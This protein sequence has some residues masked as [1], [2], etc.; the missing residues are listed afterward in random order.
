MG[1]ELICVPPC[2]DDGVVYCDLSHSLLL[3]GV[4]D[5]SEGIKKPSNKHLKA[6]GLS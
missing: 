2:D 6:L 4:L 1:V 5:L 3:L